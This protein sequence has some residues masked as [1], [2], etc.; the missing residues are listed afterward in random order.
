LDPT[1]VR[2]ALESWVHHAPSAAA[3]LERR[4]QLHYW[5]Y[6]AGDEAELE[7]LRTLSKSNPALKEVGLFLRLAVQ[8]IDETWS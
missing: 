6:R 7:K 3:E 1:G 8:D 4:A 2:R 5:L